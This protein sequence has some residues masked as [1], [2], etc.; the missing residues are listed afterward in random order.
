VY[1]PKGFKNPYTVKMRQ[2][3]MSISSVR[4]AEF[5][6]IFEAG[7]DEYERCL[8]EEAVWTNGESELV[9]ISALKCNKKGYLVFIP[10]EE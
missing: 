7:A 3:G 8:K 1:R 2:M 10:E 4:A 9:E 6:A 5:W